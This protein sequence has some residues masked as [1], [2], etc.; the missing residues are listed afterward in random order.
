MKYI[1]YGSNMNKDQMAA[2]YQ[3]GFNN[4]WF[5]DA[6]FKGHFP[7]DML[8]LFRARGITMPDLSDQ[9]SMCEPLDFW[10]L[11]YYF[12]AVIAYDKYSWPLYAKELYTDMPHTDR[13]WP[14]DADSLRDLIIRLN[15][16]Y[17]MPK[18]IISENGASYNDIVSMDGQIRDYNR[19]D[20]L[21][22]H[23]IAVHEAIE[24]GIDV[25]GYFIWSLYDNFEWAF[26]RYSRF[27]I[28]YEDFETHTRTPKESAY[29]YKKVIEENGFE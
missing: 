15:S 20:Y 7:E 18:M 16:S 6:V 14:I 8:T 5:F 11:N 1:A 21:R 27:G 17:R 23:L 26:G 4:R 22:R 12:P 29:W 2:R 19:I 25:R 13:G 10:G 9:A 24:Y 28:I 3:D